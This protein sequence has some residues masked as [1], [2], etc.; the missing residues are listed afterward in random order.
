MVISGSLRNP[1]IIELYG[2]DFYACMYVCMYVY[3]CPTIR[4]IRSQVL[5]FFFFFFFFFF[6]TVDT[7]QFMWDDVLRGWVRYAEMVS[8]TCAHSFC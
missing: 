6:F 1:H 2:S 8:C 5:H 3:I 4:P 7:D